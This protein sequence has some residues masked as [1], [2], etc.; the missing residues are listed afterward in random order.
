M[1]S[2]H[3]KK[4][5]V[6]YAESTAVGGDSKYLYELINSM[7][8]KDYKIRCYCNSV[9][10]G[11]LRE[12]IDL[13][14]PVQ[15]VKTWHSEYPQKNKRTNSFILKVACTIIGEIRIVFFQLLKVWYVFKN[16]FLIYAILKKENAD[17]LHINNGGYPA[18]ESCI[19]AIF[20]AKFAR[21]NKIVISVHNL[22]RT[23]YKLIRIFEKMIDK[24]VSRN[25]AKIIVATDSVRKSLVEKRDFPLGL[26]VKIPCGVVCPE[27]KKLPNMVR[28]QFEVSD[29]RKILIATTRFDGTKGQEYLLEALS[30]L[31]EKYRNFKCFLIGEGS[32]FQE[33]VGLSRKF[34]LQNYVVFTGYRK[35][36]PMFL[37]VADILIQ[38]S[39]A[40]ENSPYSVLEAMSYELPVIGTSVGGTSELVDNGKT[41]FIIPPKNPRALFNALSYLLKNEEK[42]KEMGRMGRERVID[43]FNMDFSVKKTMK[44][45]EA[46]AKLCQR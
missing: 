40:H 32:V 4:K 45:Y 20:A 46:G 27:H 2:C 41:G 31:K 36:V 33:M 17:I 8:D 6:F 43:K 5:L 15:V 34:K 22:A 1:N 7:K 44:L 37:A 23:R 39:V 9:I 21:V 42:A 28:K 12:K 13:A 30:L 10:S 24:Y 25:V 38:P 11:Y 14:I 3:R 29:D 26:I 35:D 16:I 18:A 19:A